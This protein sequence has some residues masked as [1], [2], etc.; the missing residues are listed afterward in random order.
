MIQPSLA[1]ETTGCVQGLAPIICLYTVC[2]ENSCCHHQQ[3]CYYRHEK[4]TLSKM[5]PVTAERNCET[6]KL[7][8]MPVFVLFV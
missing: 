3:K 7:G 6:F 5:R 2:P 1:G 8:Q 4:A